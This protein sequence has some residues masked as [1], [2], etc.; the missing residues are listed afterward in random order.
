M[1]CRAAGSRQ[2]IV[3]DCIKMEAQRHGE[4]HHQPEGSALAGHGNEV[5]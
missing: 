5:L 2:K 1:I 4:V 3:T